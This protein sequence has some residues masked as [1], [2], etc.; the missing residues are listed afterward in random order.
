MNEVVNKL[1]TGLETGTAKIDMGKGAGASL[2]KTIKK[3]KEEYA[4]FTKMTS[5][6]QVTFGDSKEAIA[7]GGRLIKLFKQLQL[8]METLEKTSVLDAKKMFPDLFDSRLDG[9]RKKLDGFKAASDQLSIKRIETKGA[10]DKL[11]E[12]EDEGKRLQSE[13]A[14]EVTLKIDT[15]EL[16]RA[17]E[18]AKKKAQEIRAEWEKKLGA[19]LTTATETEGA[20]KK[21]FTTKTTEVEAAR[22]KREA[23]GFATKDFSG[24]GD[25]ATYK[26]MTAKQVQSSKELSE[27]QKKAIVAAIKAYGQEETA[28][29]K[30]SIALDDAGKKA[31]QLRKIYENLGKTKTTELVTAVGGTQEDYDRVTASIQAQTD[32]T[33]AA[34]AAHEKNNATQNNIDSIERKIKANT[35][36][37]TEQTNRV[38]KLREVVG[39]L[40]SKVSATEL[41]KAFKEAGVEGF[42]AELLE[43]EDGIEKLRQKLDTMDQVQLDNLIKNLQG[44]GLNAEEAEDYVEKLKEEI[45]GIGDKTKELTEAEKEMQNLKNSFMQFFSLTNSI[46]LFKR[47]ITSALNTVKELDAT[48]TEASVVTDFSI[49]DMWD[50]LPQYSAEANKLGVSIN[51]MYQATTLYYQQGLKTNEAM[52]LGVETMKMAKI[53][54]MESTDATKAMTSALRGFNMELNETSATRVNDVYSQLAAVTAADTNQIATAMEK[55]ASIAA[56]ANMEFESTAAFLAQIIETTQEAP[57]TAGTALKTIIA[58]F[59]E[60]KSLREQGQLTGQDSEGETIDVNKIQTA[61]RTVGISMDG[62]FAGTEGLDSILMKL[63]E[64][65]GSLDFETQRYIATMAAGSRQQSRFIAM[66]SDYERTQE[67]VTEAQNSSGA[68]ARQYEKTMDSLESKLTKLKNAWDEFTMSLADNEVLKFAVD[69]LTNILTA[70]NKLSK[71]AGELWEPLKGIVS[72]LATIAALKLGKGV[73]NKVFDPITSGLSKKTKTTKGTS[74]TNKSP[75]QTPKD[76]TPDMTKEGGEDGTAYGNAFMRGWNKAVEQLRGSIKKTGIVGGK[77]INGAKAVGSAVGG[78]VATAGKGIGKAAVATGKGI[79]KVATTVGHGIGSAATTVGHGIGGIFK[80]KTQEEIVEAPSPTAPRKP[81]T[82]SQ[83]EYMGKD[84]SYIGQ[85]M[86]RA[87]DELTQKEL[88]SLLQQMGVTDKKKQYEIEDTA[89]QLSPFDTPIMADANKALGVHGLPQMTLSR[90]GRDEKYNPTRDM[91]Y[92]AENMKLSPFDKTRAQEVFDEAATKE[93]TNQEV[94]AELQKKGLPVMSLAEDFERVIMEEGKV[95]AR[96]DES[97]GKF[98]AVTDEEAA[99]YDQ[100]MGQPSKTTSPATGPTTQ[101]TEEKPATPAPAQT[102]GAPAKVEAPEVEEA[103]EKVEQAVT[104][105]SKD[106]AARDKDDQNIQQEIQ[107]NTEE[108]A[109]NTE[110]NGKPSANPKKDDNS[111]SNTDTPTQTD[112]EDLDQDNNQ[113]EVDPT[114]KKGID[115]AAQAEGATKFGNAISATS[116]AVL[117]LSSALGQISPAAGKAAES[118]S[119][120]ATIGLTIG[121]VISIIPSLVAGFKA[122][123]A[124]INSIW[125]TNPWLLIIGGIL[126][127]I[128][129]AIIIFAKGSETAADRI[130]KLDQ[131]VQHFQKE[132]QEAKEEL[133]TMS[134]QRKALEGLSKTLSGLT[135]GTEEWTSAL[136]SNNQ[137]VLELM[138]KYGFLSTLSGTVVYG[139][140]GE[141][142]ITTEGWEQLED[143]LFKQQINAMSSQMAAQTEVIKQQAISKVTGTGQ[144]GLLGDLLTAGMWHMEYTGTKGDS[145]SKKEAA[146]S[147]T[148]SVN[149]HQ[150]EWNM[151]TN[152]SQQGENGYLGMLTYDQLTDIT[153]KITKSGLT[154]ENKDEIRTIWDSLGYNDGSHDFEQ[155]YGA[156]AKAGDKFT[157]FGAII[158]EGTE[159]QKAYVKTIISANAQLSGRLQGNK[160]EGAILDSVSQAYED[161]ETRMAELGST[162]SRIGGDGLMDSNDNIR[163]ND[164]VK[165]AITEYATITGKSEED[166]RKAIKE[167][168]LTEDMMVKALNQAEMAEQI[169]KAIDAT[170]DLYDKLETSN[171]KVYRALTGVSSKEGLGLTSADL[172]EIEGYGGAT[173]EENVRKLLENAGVTTDDYAKALGYTSLDDYVNA[174]TTNYE[175]AERAKENAYNKFKMYSAD[176]EDAQLET[177]L[178][179]LTKQLE[180]LGHQTGLTIFQIQ[181]LSSGLTDAMINGGNYNDLLGIMSEVL[182]ST[183]TDQISKVLDIFSGVDWTDQNSV[184]SAI[185][186]IRGLGVEVDNSLV[187]KIYSAAK[188]IKQF[189]VDRLEEALKRLNEVIK[190]VTDKIQGNVKVFSKEE[191]D[192][193]VEQGISNSSFTR[194]GIDEYVYLGETTLLLQNIE[195]LVSKILGEMKGDIKEAVEKGKVIEANWDKKESGQDYTDG[196]VAEALINGK[197]TADYVGRDR[198]EAIIKSFG[199]GEG[200]DLS[201]LDETGL[202]SLLM[203]GYKNYY[204]IGGK[205][206]R[207]NEEQEKVINRDYVTTQYISD[208][209]SGKINS[210]SGTVATEEVKYYG[211]MIE[212]KN[213]LE[214]RGLYAESYTDEDY[215]LLEKLGYNGA[216]NFQEAQAWAKQY[217]EDV[218]LYEEALDAAIASSPGLATYINDITEKIKKQNP[219]LAQNTKLI[220]QLAVQSYYASTR[221]DGLNQVLSDQAD[222]LNSSNPREAGAA[223]ELIAA[224]A[225]LVFGE[226]FDSKMVLQY[227]DL[228]IAMSKGGPAAAEAWKQL[229]K[230]SFDTSIVNIDNEALKTDL[231]NLYS[232]LEN[233]PLNVPVQITGTEEMVANWDASVAQMAK[234]GIAL[235]KHT[236]ENGNITY[237]ATRIDNLGTTT[238]TSPGGGGSKW[239]NSHD[240]LYNR[241]EEVNKLLRQREQI[242]RN[243]DRLLRNRNVGYK[244]ILANQKKELAN[245]KAQREEQE[246]IQAGKAKEIQDLINSKQ[247][248]KYAQYFSY[249]KDTGEINID[250]DKVNKLRGS[251]GEGFDE[252]LSKLEG[253]RDQWQDSQDALDEIEDAVTEIKDARKDRYFD[254][255]DQ[256]KEALVKERQDEID[257]LSEINDSINDTNSKLLDSMQQ[258]IDEYRQ[259]RDNQK[260][261]EEIADKQRRLSYLQMDTSGANAMEILNLQKEIDEAQED[262]TDTLIDQKISELQKQNDE[263]AEQR[264]RQID[265]AQAQLDYYQES[266]AVWQDVYN[267]L[268]DEESFDENGALKPNGPLAQLLQNAADY[269]GMSNLAQQEW[270]VETAQLVAEGLTHVHGDRTGVEGEAVTFTSNTGE[271]ISGHWDANGNVVDESGN[272]HEGV[273]QDMEGNWVQSEPPTEPEQD[274]PEKHEWNS[275]YTKPWDSSKTIKKGS[276]KKYVKGLQ[277]ALTELGYDPK[278]IDGSY[279]KN[280]T[281]AVSAFQADQEGWTPTGKAGPK[282]KEALSKLFQY[283]TG[284]LA[285]FTGPAWLDGTKSK[286]EYILN[287]DQTKAFFNLVDVLGSLQSGNS[288]TAQNNGDNTYDIDINVESIGSDYDVEQL[289]DKVKSLINEDARYRNN[290]AINLMR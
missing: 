184:D 259:T 136:I 50:R 267:L 245:L 60:V 107:Q 205:K 224:Q 283:K 1:K 138:E 137:Q 39:Q 248:K 15:T 25:R 209:K 217:Y 41:Q 141:L 102:T 125:T 182:K 263:A 187:G 212:T 175:A 229:N 242:E 244:D 238:I 169:E 36:A 3:F 61:L 150:T 193:L 250:W 239:K 38:N 29:K 11:K 232:Q 170:A 213:W 143:Q 80:R 279:G 32:A 253:L 201:T 220:K 162:S 127:A 91:D 83:F 221:V 266:G 53:A 139:A 86:G 231:T 185:E 123:C 211:S 282:T 288:K 140:N 280:T 7:S 78:A 87:H 48:M 95:I 202:A 177:G 181:G 40:E 227:K 287:A 94:N 186:A 281:A 153:T 286:P 222:K 16:D 90:P 52:E 121:Q 270:W 226:H 68:S 76:L 20:A 62:F 262:Y 188:T 174:L 289:A 34:N 214:G 154:Y 117:M 108:A 230:I 228:F 233:Q 63:A 258:Q 235:T 164:L 88:F 103:V 200:V 135:K 116:S 194:T 98:V 190:T 21:A 268:N 131:S 130:E 236:D 247:G 44:F 82:V 8:S 73:L 171:N 197:L 42:N 183:P 218:I 142:T 166:V 189:N 157:E 43:T 265:I 156:I 191:R 256:I 115:W 59:S 133:E 148:Q 196:E 12:L 274:E 145:K 118:I 124:A 93:W 5:G 110:D 120:F 47:A 271:T 260:T 70:V 234:A 24:S 160:N 206:L 101:T 219:T 35:A 75:S 54:G 69:F 85:S 9:L 215:A 23:A 198:L 100:E 152:T 81:I 92:F 269:T 272:V 65:W 122:V 119:K 146:D 284:G 77:V 89:Y 246:L 96:F 249:D 126:L 72:L 147:R 192:A 257:K 240:K 112:E 237:V 277:W 109:Q 56:A 290:N 216:K 104:K 151:T 111:T 51:S 158:T 19:K 204:G 285:D 99:Q 276:A 207:E 165:N 261:E 155:F 172:A 159:K 203:E 161:Y 2:L 129:A 208:L 17:A 27:E 30:L 49:G 210:V 254:L 241:Y 55:T 18:E 66:M 4:S 64:K 31:S 128:T 57:E 199:L 6:D 225:K 144:H 106:E 22:K 255:E 167:G 179:A 45:G 26:G 10:E 275:S 14:K 173:T 134:E 28:I 180:L 149:F 58:R 163:D 178:N 97:V 79:G 278:G 33:N 223:A 264:Q 251:K 67:L 132:A 71:G 46:Q 105:G 168:A 13:L 243:Y 113:P 37:Y 114:P 252:F 74:P 195:G 273:H 84:G 176:S